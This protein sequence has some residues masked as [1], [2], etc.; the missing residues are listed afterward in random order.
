M[1]GNLSH[2]PYFFQR[3]KQLHLQILLT[4]QFVISRPM[5]ELPQDSCHWLILLFPFSYLANTAQPP[6]VQSA[7]RLQPT[8]FTSFLSPQTSCQQSYV[9]AAAFWTWPFRVF[10]YVFVADLFCTHAFLPPKLLF[11]L[12][13]HHFPT[14]LISVDCF[15]N[16]DTNLSGYLFRAPPPL[17]TTSVH[18]DF[19]PFEMVASEFY[20]AG[21]LLV[22]LEF[23]RRV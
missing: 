18:F 14:Y 2:S 12:E 8:V 7:E 1:S 23:Q 9:D 15:M 13:T 17:T 3:L 6:L 22:F 11:I 21:C 19:L 20:L 16:E 5:F 10:P 4:L